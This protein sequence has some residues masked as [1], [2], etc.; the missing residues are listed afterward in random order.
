MKRVL[1]KKALRDGV[2][3]PFAEL[4]P[5]DQVAVLEDLVAHVRGAPAK[6]PEPPAR[7]EGES[8]K[9]AKAAA[10]QA[11]IDYL[12][13]EARSGITIGEGDVDALS[14]ARAATVQSALLGPGGLDPARVFMARSDKV[15]AQDGKVRLELT[16]K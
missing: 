12:Q 14:Q 6:L 16:L 3:V 7:A 11:A 15:T 13:G 2:P 10:Q 9:D 8:R 4:E 5:D 1:K